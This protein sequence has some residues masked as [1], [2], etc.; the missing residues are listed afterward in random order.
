MELIPV[1]HAPSPM[2]A[3]IVKGRL[4]AEGLHPIVPGEDLSDEFG[5]AAKLAGTLA[6]RVLVPASEQE[7]AL[8]CLAAFDEHAPE[9]SGEEPS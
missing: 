9:V 7:L 4:M 2:V 6:V 8:Q 5:M 3:Q 1:Y